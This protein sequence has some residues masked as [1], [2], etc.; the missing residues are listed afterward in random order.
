MQQP[1]L[2]YFNSQTDPVIKKQLFLFGELFPDM[3]LAE[4]KSVCSNLYISRIYA[5]GLNDPLYY[6][7]LFE[8]WCLGKQTRHFTYKGEVGWHVKK[9]EPFLSIEHHETIKEILL[10]NEDT[11]A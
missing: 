6:I 4:A 7:R 3:T 5:R 9:N 8:H 2:D 11:I 1:V 10:L